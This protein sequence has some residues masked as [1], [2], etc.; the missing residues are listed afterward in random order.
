[1]TSRGPGLFV[2]RA[3]GVVSAV[4]RSRGAGFVVPNFFSVCN[5][6][7]IL[8]LQETMTRV[9]GVACCGGEKV[10]SEAHFKG[11]L[12]RLLGEVGFGCAGAA[13]VFPPEGDIYLL[14]MQHVFS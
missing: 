2:L 12:A 6:A 5:F 4:A 1:M 10:S 11:E 8:V 9:G 14:L 13:F 7:R 3:G